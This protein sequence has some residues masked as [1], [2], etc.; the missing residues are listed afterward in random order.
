MTHTPADILSMTPA[1]L[2]EA[3]AKVEG[4]EQKIYLD[5]FCI[6]PKI[7]WLTPEG[8]L[9]VNLPDWTGNIAD[10]W[11]LAEEIPDIRLRKLK[12][13]DDLF[14]QCS[15]DYS[16]KFPTIVVYAESAPLSISR[17]WLMW[18]EME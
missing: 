4:Y 7:Y 5:E 2:R 15:C 16:C 17:A 10:A 9:V 13:G 1:E 8:R 3:I 11:K 12:D 14:W 18:K 6:N